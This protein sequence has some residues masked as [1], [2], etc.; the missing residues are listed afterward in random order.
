MKRNYNLASKSDMRRFA[1]DL[2]KD[3]Y[4]DVKRQALRSTYAINCPNCE[5][6][7]LISPGQRHCPICG[8]DINFK[9]DFDF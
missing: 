4:N 2:E 5:H 6:I 3:I 7:I 8:T 9:L 1:R